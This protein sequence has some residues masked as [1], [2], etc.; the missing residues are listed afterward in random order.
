MYAPS[1]MGNGGWLVGNTD[2][3]EVL[4]FAAIIIACTPIVV[5]VLA[6]VILL[7]LLF[8]AI[9]VFIGLTVAAVFAVFLGAAIAA[10]SQ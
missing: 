9:F 3:H 2:T 5:A 4:A 7:I 8:A 10:A 1:K 6:G